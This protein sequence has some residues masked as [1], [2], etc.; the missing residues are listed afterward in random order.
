MTLAR[1]VKDKSAAIKFIT[2]FVTKFVDK[3]AR[4]III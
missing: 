2:K 3:C 4:K 1:E